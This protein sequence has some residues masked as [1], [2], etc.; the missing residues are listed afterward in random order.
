MVAQRVLTVLLVMAGPTFGQPGPNFL[1]SLVTSSDA[2]A[3]AE[4]Y[5][6]ATTPTAHTVSVTAVR[7]IK[8]DLIPGKTLTATY[9]TRQP[10]RQGSGALL[11]KG[12][13]VVFLNHSSDGSWQL[14]NCQGPGLGI[15]EAFWPAAN[16]PVS[17]NSPLLDKAAISQLI[18]VLADGVESG[19]KI[20]P[21]DRNILQALVPPPLVEPVYRRWMDSA[22]PTLREVAYRGLVALNDI[23]ALVRAVSEIGPQTSSGETLSAAFLSWRTNDATA[24]SAIGSYATAPG[25]SRLVAENGSAVLAR[26]HSA[27]TLPFFYLMLN[28]PYAFVRQNALQGFSAFATGMRVAEPGADQAQ[29]FDEVMNPGRTRQPNAFDTPDV[30]KNLHFGAFSTPSD[31]QTYTSFWRA[32]YEANRGSIKSH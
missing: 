9:V 25:V 6:T 13:A 28:S 12:T 5:E 2:I 16:F 22:N 26:I 8:G 31:E 27:D 32:W 14:R 15:L 1:E 17:V 4:I 11:G 21:V 24:I 19:G 18:A 30:R 23:A 10:G 29:A 3:L 20:A 7:T